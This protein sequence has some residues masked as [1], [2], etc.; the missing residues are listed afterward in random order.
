MSRFQPKHQHQRV[1]VRPLLP[2]LPHWLFWQPLCDLRGRPKRSQRWPPGG[3]IRG[4]PGSG[5]PGFCADSAAVGHLCQPEW[6]LG[7]GHRWRPALQAEQLCDRRQSLLQH[8]PP[9]VH[10]RG[11]LPGRGEACQ[12]PQDADRRMCSGHLWPRLAELPG[13]WRALPAVPKGGA[14][15]GR[16]I[17]CGGQQLLLF[18]F[19]ELGHGA[20]CLCVPSVNHSFLLQ[21]HNHSSQQALC[22]FCQC[23]SSEQRPPQTLLQDGPLHHRGFCCLLAPL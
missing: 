16:A 14:E 12:L 23:K 13:A 18:S 22:R 10:E 8:L 5:R 20:V 2:H 17:L 4:Q 7:V 9:D 19:P 15:R 3:Q 6:P 1:T 21:H 11:P